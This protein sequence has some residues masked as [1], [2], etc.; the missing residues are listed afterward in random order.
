MQSVMPAVFPFDLSM[1]VEYSG[2]ISLSAAASGGVLDKSPRTIN[3]VARPVGIL[4]ISF[5]AAPLV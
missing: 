3:I 1:Q 5:Q 2:V 4:I